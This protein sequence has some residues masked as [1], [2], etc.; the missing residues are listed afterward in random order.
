LISPMRSS[1]HASV[2]ASRRE[3]RP[4]RRNLHHGVGVLIALG[5]SFFLLTALLPGLIAPHAPDTQNPQDALQPPSRTYLLG[6]DQFGRDIFSRVVFGSRIAMLVGV[7]SILIAL[8]AGVPLGLV[9]GYRGGHLDALLMRLQDA[10]LS[11][12][13]VLLAL[14]IIASFGASVLNVVLTIA[15][16]YTP[17]FARLVRGSVLHIRTRE[18]VTA[19]QAAGASAWRVMVRVILPNAVAPITNIREQ[20]AI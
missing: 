5:N 20:G 16:V 13:P 9:A 11:F 3:N 10:L 17:R 2:P 12:P 4:H 18:F 15:F 14:L 6:T 7:G 19:S 1:I 8:I